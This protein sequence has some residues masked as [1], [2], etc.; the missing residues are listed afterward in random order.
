MS[1]LSKIETHVIDGLNRLAFQYRGKSNFENLL[2][3]FL[4]RFQNL[5][6]CYS[7]FYDRLSLTNSSGQ[8]LDNFGKIVGQNRDG[9]NDE[10]YRILLRAKVGINVS[11]SL[12]ENLINIV[13]ELTTK[14]V[15]TWEISRRRADIV[16]HTSGVDFR[17]D[18][19]AE[20]LIIRVVNDDFLNNLKPGDTMNGF[21]ITENKSLLISGFVWRNLETTGI[22]DFPVIGESFEFIF[23]SPMR[24]PKVQYMN[25]GGFESAVGSDGIAL[26]PVGTVMLSLQEVV[27]AGSRVNYLSIYKPE[28]ESFAFSGTDAGGGFGEGELATLYT[29]PGFFEFNAGEGFGSIKDP[30]AGGQFAA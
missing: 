27:A 8:Q 4:N 28:A 23:S 6:N 5:E 9:N 16:G 17:Y 29:I 7:D 10:T 22:P 25:L 2:R 26:S 20:G 1:Q 14:P 18:T 11:R 3:V 13:K 19:N 15:E 12:P 21:E 30:L 24:I